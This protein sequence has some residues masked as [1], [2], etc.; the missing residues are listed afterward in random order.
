[1]V[2]CQLSHIVNAIHF[3]FN[4]GY[5]QSLKT[6]SK[7]HDQLIYRRQLIYLKLIKDNFVMYLKNP[8]ITLDHI[9]IH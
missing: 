5:F 1:M 3:S 4:Q 9:S 6:D 7:T 8:G 2:E